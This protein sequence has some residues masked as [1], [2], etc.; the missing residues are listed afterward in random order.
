MT[1]RGGHLFLAVWAVFASTAV[2]TEPAPRQQTAARPEGRT[3]SPGEPAATAP[4]PG[5]AGQ[6]P[7]AAPSR[8]FLNTYCATCHNQRAKTAG[9]ALDTLDVANVSSDAEVWEKVVV[10]LRAGLMPPL[11]M[12]RPS[13]AAVDEFAT[14]LET[15]LDRAAEL[16]PNPGRTE[17]FHRLNRAEYQNA[18]RDLLAL[19]VNLTA[20]LPPDEISYGFDNM[21]GVLK[22]SPLLIERYLT[23]ARKV[24]RLALGT[25]GPAN[26]DVY[27]VPDQLDQDVRLEG[28]PLGTRGGTRVDYVAPRD[29]DYV[30]KARLGRGV[31]YDIPHF[32]GPQQL[33]VSVDGQQV[34]VFTVPDTPGVPLNPERAVDQGKPAAALDR[35]AQRALQ[36]PRDID[37]NWTVQVPL[38]A[39]VHEIRA[40]FLAKTGAMSEGFRRPYLKPYLGTGTNDQR[41]TREGA[42]LRELEILGPLNPGAA[43][44]SPSYKR[45]FVCRPGTAAGAGQARP[46]KSADEA[47]CARKILATLARRAYRRPVIESDLNVLLGFYGEARAAGGF[48]A[49][50]EA[51]L[52]RLL[53]SPSF[54]IRTEFTPANA[55]GDGVYRINDVDL[56]SRLS[57]FLWSSIPDDELLDLANKGTLHEPAVL[58]RQA[59]R[60]LADPRSQ[61]FTTNFAGQWLSLRRLK[62]IVP[63]SYLF[64][65]YGDTL[66]RAFQR[67]AELFFDSIL[68]EDRSAI[69]LL[70]ANYT[71]VNEPLAKHYGLPEV[72]GMNFR[73]V[74]LP[75][76]SPRRGLLGKGAI[77]AST[78]LP[79]RTSPVVRGKWVLQNI[80]GAPPPEPPPNVPSLQENGE[81]VTRVNTLRER[82]EQHRASPACASCHKLMDPIGFALERFDPVGRY[83]TFDEN[84]VPIDSTGVYVDGTRIDGPDGLRQ[85]LVNHAPQFVFTVTS[86]LLTY[87]LGRGVEY[88][89]APAVRAIL[90]DA[91]P[92]NYPLSSLVLGVVKSGPFQMRRAT[93]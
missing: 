63:D 69:D 53:V 48:D 84:F 42:S 89:D 80:L 38:K 4:H 18:I 70:T 28:M 9:L 68:R 10:K 49:G 71:F 59:R 76:D 32:L 24:S 11:G 78:A 27:R 67:E 29:G 36:T 85:V 25:P 90:R 61:A 8:Q 55:P 15:A 19:D 45:V 12:P 40:T 81:R 57:F 91:A 64:P 16:R 26:G 43:D 66:A 23:A 20:L 65:D 14:S 86:K 93:S 79:N 17:T 88:Y 60:M 21:A 3:A 41:E 72:K 58:E 56:A 35:A 74:V 33:E 75:D 82:L 92:G 7:I 62:E 39:G 44:E 37:A 22:L 31:D 87:A 30:I 73:R 47:E 1:T 54:L 34:K 52:Q 2:S 51:A 50:I 46:A 13:P 83:R 6:V 5:P 77:L